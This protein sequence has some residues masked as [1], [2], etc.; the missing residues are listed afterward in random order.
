MDRLKAESVNYVVLKGIWKCTMY[1]NSRIFKI[2][3]LG[4]D[5]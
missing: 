5:T 2:K 3:S 4:N 1:V